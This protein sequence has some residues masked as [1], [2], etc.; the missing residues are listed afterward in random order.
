MILSVQRKSQYNPR[1]SSNDV[2]GFSFMLNTPAIDISLTN[3]P[4]VLRLDKEQIKE[5]IRLLLSPRDKEASDIIPIQFR[6]SNTEGTFYMCFSYARCIGSFITQ[7]DR[8]EILT[9]LFQHGDE[10]V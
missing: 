8:V 2:I 5:F 6:Y 10:V 4:H 9:W 1:G 3:Y 7:A